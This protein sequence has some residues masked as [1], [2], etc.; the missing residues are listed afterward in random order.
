M[1]APSAAHNEGSATQGAIEVICGC[2]FAGKTA[3]LIKELVAAADAGLRVKAAKHALDDRYDA[4]NLATHDQRRLPAKAVRSAEELLDLAADADVLGIDEAHFFGR[5]LTAVC[6][7]LR[8]Q[9]KRVL[10]VGLANDAW[11]RPFPPVPQLREIA[12]GVRVL[13][14]PCA[15][16]GQPAHYSQRMVPVTDPMM[17]GGPGD[18]EP[19][20]QACFEALPGPAPAY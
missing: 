6:E 1:A 13:E 17:V 12:D 18:Y 14:V 19:R 7:Q 11:G 5:G 10:V 16:C 20:C 8:A 15:K 3:L 9:G 4:T 2:M